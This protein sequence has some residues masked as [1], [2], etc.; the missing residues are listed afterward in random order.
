MSLKGQAQLEETERE[1]PP[2]PCF[3]DAQL[4]HK[5]G[6]KIANWF[7]LDFIQQFKRFTEYR[8]EMM[9]MTHKSPGSKRKYLIKRHR[10]NK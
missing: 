3:R 7:S 10:G 4:K 2:L 6:E 8:E 5:M 1:C 9:K